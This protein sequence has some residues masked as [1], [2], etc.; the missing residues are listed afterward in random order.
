MEKREVSIK[1]NLIEENGKFIFIIKEE[2]KKE[3]KV[4]KKK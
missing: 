3:K 1:N 2:K 4:A